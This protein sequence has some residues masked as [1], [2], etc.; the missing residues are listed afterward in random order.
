MKDSACLVL[1]EIAGLLYS[2]ASEA[3][4]LLARQL[5]DQLLSN[6]NFL[7]LMQVERKEWGRR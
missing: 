4:R 5:A 1:R 7:R 2:S 3:G 6:P